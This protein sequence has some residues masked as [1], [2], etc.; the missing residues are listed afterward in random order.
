MD[1]SVFGACVESS[2]RQL[3]VHWQRLMGGPDPGMIRGLQCTCRAC[4][5]G[6]DLQAGAGGGAAGA[7]AGHV[8]A[9]GPQQRAKQGRERGRPARGARMH[10]LR[11]G[12]PGERL[13]GRH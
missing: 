5:G 11:G 13:R 8:P 3:A 9:A 4:E 2:R 6:G 1:W 12:V 10:P 7:H